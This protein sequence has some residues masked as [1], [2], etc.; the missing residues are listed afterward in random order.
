[1][2]RTVLGDIQP[3]SID[4]ILPHE[5]LLCDFSRV[6][7]DRNHV[8][9][10]SHIAI[11][12]L[13]HLNDDVPPAAGRKHALVEMTLSD[14]GRN[15][16]GLKRISAAADVHV[17][18]GTGW[19]LE[20]YYPDLIHTT[21]T[22]DLADGMIREI[23]EGV[24]LADGSTIRAGVIG[25]IGTHGDSLSP[26][27]ERVLRAAARASNATGAAISTH[28][29]MYPTG[30]DQLRILDE[31]G[32]DTKRV[33]IGHVDTFLDYEYHLEILERGAYLQYDTCGREH[34]MPDALRV[35]MLQRLVQEGWEE[36]LLLSS[37]RCH[38]T[39]LKMRGG[40]GY[41]WTLTGFC[42]LLRDA[43][44]TDRTIDLMTHENPLRLLS[45]MSDDQLRAAG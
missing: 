9:N 20:P 41:S 2:L 17:V 8:F 1:M 35:E 39:D 29:F 19:Y 23:R 38:M 33:A 15:P 25:E 22:G 45:G 16:A 4:R 5:H 30:R 14:L 32:V 13:K 6:T 42:D 44:I 40:L 43:G 18:M 3:E 37:D 26:A 31:E 28:A 11:S 12:E 21:H 7:N 24:Q 27:E 34:L 10:N 36:S